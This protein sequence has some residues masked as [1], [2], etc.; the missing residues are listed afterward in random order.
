MSRDLHL[1][2]DERDAQALQAELLTAD[3]FRFLLKHDSVV[4]ALRQ[5]LDDDGRFQLRAT[6]TALDGDAEGEVEPSEGER[7][8]TEADAVKRLRR[9]RGAVLMWLSEPR[10][11]RDR[12]DLP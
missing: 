3:W 5:L 7:E 2:L 9:I 4:T 1:T 6:M 10:A 11:L 8:R 12:P